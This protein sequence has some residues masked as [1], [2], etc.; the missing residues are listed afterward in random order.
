MPHLL[1]AGEIPPDARRPIRCGQ[2][3]FRRPTALDREPLA[4]IEKND[5]FT[6]GDRCDLACQQPE[7]V[8]ELGRT[9][10]LARE[11]EQRLHRFR[12]LARGCRLL[13]QPAGQRSGY[14]GDSQENKQ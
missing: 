8:V 14:K 2:L 11:I 13:P 3:I 4:L 9:G 1:A 10:E 12:A 7:H 6:F 5:R